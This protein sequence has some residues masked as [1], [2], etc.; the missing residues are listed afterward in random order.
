MTVTRP[1][2]GQASVSVKLELGDGDDAE[3][4]LQAP[5]PL[6]NRLHGAQPVEELVAPAALELVD[7]ALALE[8]EQVG[9][10]LPQGQDLAASHSPQRLLVDHSRQLPPS[11]FQTSQARYS[12]SAG[13]ASAGL[14]RPPTEYQVE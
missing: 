5:P 2:M 3:L 7:H 4:A 1:I 10:E 8:L 6:E 12:S 14:P 13:E 11:R 9:R